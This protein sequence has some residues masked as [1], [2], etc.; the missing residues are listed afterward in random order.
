MRAGAWATV[1]HS[2]FAR[3]ATAANAP[4]P[5]VVEDSAHA[6]F[7]S[8]VFVGSTAVSLAS[9]SPEARAQFARVNWFVAS[10]PPGAAPARSR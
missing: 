8:N 3:N 5:L 10:R 4:R 9:G 2:V 6:D 7:S 1:T